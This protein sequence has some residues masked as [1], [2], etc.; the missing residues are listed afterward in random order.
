MKL[1]PLL[2]VLVSIAQAASAASQPVMLDFHADWCGPCRQMRP[3]VERLAEKGYPIKS[4]D[5]DKSPDMAEKYGIGPIPTFVVVDADGREIDR[6]SGAQPASQLAQFY[7][8][9]RDRAKASQG[10]DE[11][12]VEPEDGDEE[13]EA[14]DDQA[15]P[16]PEPEPEPAKRPSK[17][18]VNPKPW[19]TVVRIKVHGSGSIG[20]G[21]G[22]IIHSSPRES[23]ILTCAHIFKL[24]GQRQA[25]PGKFPRKI[26]ID[27]FD[28]RPQGRE[29]EVHPIETVAGE[30]LDYD[31]NLDVGLIRI[32]PGRR[33]PASRVV[34]PH[35]QPLQHMGML[36][37]GCSEGHDAT[38]W[39]TRIIDPKMRGLSGNQAY[40]AIEC[41]RAP[42]QGRSGG[43]LYTNDGYIAGVCNFAEPRGDRGLYATPNSIYSILDRN[44]LAVLYESPAAGGGSTLMADRGGVPRMIARGQS[45]DREEPLRAA[46]REGDVTI[47]DPEIVFSNRSP[48]QDRRNGR[49]QPAS[50]TGDR[51]LA[52]HPV[53]G[54]PAPKLASIGT[55][56]AT[57]IDMDAAT[58]NDHFPPP[59]WDRDDDRDRDAGFNTEDVAPR[60]ETRKPAVGRTSEWRPVRPSTA[61]AR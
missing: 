19:E 1:A 8:N 25:P 16:E 11:G 30:A 59:D 18:F 45:P 5:V 50:S 17:P 36:T 55:I 54:E 60:T 20:Y 56:E 44:K 28:G 47:P 9:A 40:E 15:E 61:G 13:A 53:G 52:W 35:W 43:G 22:T 39:E 33:L 38:A 23:L 21:S 42:K 48:L 29:R 3:A 32:R 31:F 51:H 58:D 10:D 26:T 14:V 41:L 4:I 46:V 27:L 7:I 2:L 34:P 6:V 37:V 24:D 49:V 12:A 57:D